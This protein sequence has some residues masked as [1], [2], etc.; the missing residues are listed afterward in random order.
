MAWGYSLMRK[1][2]TSRDTAASSALLSERSGEDGV[3]QVKDGAE[4]KII[5]VRECRAGLQKFLEQTRF[6]IQ[7]SADNVNGGSGN[8]ADVHGSQTLSPLPI[9]LPADHARPAHLQL[10]RKPVG[11]RAQDSGEQDHATAHRPERS[12]QSHSATGCG[13]SEAN[14]RVLNSFRIDMRAPSTEPGEADWRN[15]NAFDRN[16]YYG[17]TDFA[18]VPED[19]ECVGSIRLSSNKERAA[20]HAFSSDAA[21]RDFGGR[22]TLSSCKDRSSRLHLA[23]QIRHN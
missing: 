17:P 13:E 6:R 9:L 21:S 18:F 2:K 14:S 5:L 7:P 8:H 20:A 15:S 11:L 12:W 19:L 22:Q 3:Q 16:T 1:R 10:N 4:K 23:N